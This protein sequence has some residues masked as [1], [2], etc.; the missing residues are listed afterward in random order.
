V[1]DGLYNA[2]ITFY[3][4]AGYLQAFGNT[5]SPRRSADSSGLSTTLKVQPKEKV[6]TC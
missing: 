5:F 2:F 3:S 4:P 1:L 6:T